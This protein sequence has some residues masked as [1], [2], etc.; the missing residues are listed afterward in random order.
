MT[1]LAA[2]ANIDRIVALLG[3]PTLRLRSGHSRTVDGDD[4]LWSTFRVADPLHD[5]GVPVPT[6]G[7]TAIGPRG[8]D[9]AVAQEKSNWCWAAATQMIRRHVSLPEKKQCEIAGTR[10]GRPCCSEPNDCNVKLELSRIGSLLEENRIKS[11]HE[12]AQ[13]ESK[14]FWDQLFRQQPLLL[15]DIFDNGIDGHVRVVFGR[16]ITK[17]RQELIRIADPAEAKVSSTT[18]EALQQSSWRQTW[19]SL[20]VSDG[21]R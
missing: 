12:Q 14:K 17:R 13:L 19:H 18:F 16:Q 5:Q 4:R 2:A 7:A 9:I 6:V 20:E 8:T 1:L 10:L 21:A 11:K 3:G 15:A